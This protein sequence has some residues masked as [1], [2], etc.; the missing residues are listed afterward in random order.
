MKGRADRTHFPRKKKQPRKVRFIRGISV[1]L[2]LAMATILLYSYII[3][4]L[5]NTE[6]ITLDSLVDDE[7]DQLYM[8]LDT[9]TGQAYA[10]AKEASTKIEQG[11]LNMDMDDLKS[12]L[13]SDQFN[14]Q[15][16]ELIR[17][18]IE[19][20][21]LNGINNYKNGI[22]IMTTEGIYEDFS[23]NRAPEDA[24]SEVRDWKYEIS[25][26]FNPE[27]EKNAIESLLTHSDDL[28]VTESINYMGS[29]STDK[30]KKISCA[31]YEILKD[32]YKNEGLE[33]FKNYQ[34]YVPVYITDSGDIFGQKD[35]VQGIRQNTH[36]LI[37]VQE[38]NLYDQV[39]A[40]T[41]LYDRLKNNDEYNSIQERYHYATIVLYFLG[42]CYAISLVIMVLVYTSKYN[43]YIDE[44]VLNE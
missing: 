33:G 24:L 26:S 15:L 37:V 20:K 7:F 6:K 31:N 13:D 3:E 16:Y 42:F 36:K 41:S 34:I 44:E 23:Y 27:L 4:E 9:L 2:I 1:I 8:F 12:D 40:E 5:T 19:D 18:S 28:I 25:H 21:S 11:I 10:Q 39:E 17:S 29:C 43:K 30:H 35:I 22:I 14:L 38:F 32:I